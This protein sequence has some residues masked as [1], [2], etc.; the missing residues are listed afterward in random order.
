MSDGAVPIFLNCFLYGQLINPV[1]D[2]FKNAL[3]KA[4]EDVVKN[5]I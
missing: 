2:R 1:S 5:G 3:S 4:I